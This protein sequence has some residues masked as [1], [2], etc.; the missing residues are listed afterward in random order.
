MFRSNRRGPTWLQDWCHHPN[1]THLKFVPKSF[2]AQ[3]SCCIWSIQCH[4]SII[5]TIIQCHFSIICSIIQCSIESVVLLISLTLAR[6]LWLSSILSV[7]PSASSG[8]S[9]WKTSSYS[10]SRRISTAS[11]F[12]RGWCMPRGSAR[13]EFSKSP[14]KQLAIKKSSTRP[15]AI[16][17]RFAV[18]KNMQIMRFLLV[19]VLVLWLILVLYEF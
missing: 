2:W 9:A 1:H 16:G 13:T 8:T 7:W 15:C 4:F 5:C 14:S 3:R 19:L 6:S 11:A 17:S 12:L 10:T 18:S